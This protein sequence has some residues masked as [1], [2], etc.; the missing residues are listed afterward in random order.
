M[1]TADL[2]RGADVFAR[3]VALLLLITPIVV[4]QPDTPKRTRVY[5]YGHHF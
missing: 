4:V 3:L 5:R 1:D 2:D